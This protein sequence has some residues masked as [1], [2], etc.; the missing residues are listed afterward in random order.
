[1][2]H[3]NENV[4]GLGIESLLKVIKEKQP[5]AKILLVSPI[6]LGDDVWK[7]EYDPEFDADSVL[8]SKRLKGVYEEIAKRYQTEFLAASDYAQFS[9]ADMEHMDEEGHKKLADAIYEKI[10]PFVA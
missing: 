6:H 10:L 2:Y 1:M 4:I 9:A 7:S 3:A 5:T 8:V